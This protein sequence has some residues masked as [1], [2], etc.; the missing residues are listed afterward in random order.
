MPPTTAEVSER[1]RFLVGQLTTIDDPY[2][3]IDAVE[4][5]ESLGGGHL[6]SHREALLTAWAITRPDDPLSDPDALFGW[7]SEASATLSWLS[8]GQRWQA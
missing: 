6:D 8:T 5:A 3:V 2:D 4:L 1:A 7:L